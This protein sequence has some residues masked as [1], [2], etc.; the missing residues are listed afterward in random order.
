MG[1]CVDCVNFKVKKGWTK[2]YC[3]IGMIIYAD[4]GNDKNRE[5]KYKN[6]SRKTI[7]ERGRHMDVLNNRNCFEGDE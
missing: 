7:L 5:F 2:V 1:N 4:K 6:S 3:K